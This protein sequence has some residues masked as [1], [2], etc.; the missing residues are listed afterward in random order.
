MNENGLSE[1]MTSSP[2]DSPLWHVLA[3]KG[4]SFLVSFMLECEK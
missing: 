1:W 4:E 2:T 3:C